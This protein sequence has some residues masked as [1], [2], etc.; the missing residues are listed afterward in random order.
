MVF[1]AST[2][3]PLPGPLYV[4][5]FGEVSKLMEFKVRY[6]T[7][8]SQNE[9]ANSKYISSSCDDVSFLSYS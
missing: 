2:G 5:I 8:L 4:Q 7:P 9:S 6:F 3:E 1:A